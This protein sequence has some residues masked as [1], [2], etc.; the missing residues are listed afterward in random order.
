MLSI[1]ESIGETPRVDRGDSRRYT[2]RNVC[3]VIQVTRAGPVPPVAFDSV[4]PEFLDTGNRQE[5][6][7]RRE[8]RV[9][10]GA[11][12]GVRQ[13]PVR[14]HVPAGPIIL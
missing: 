14:S 4:L 12:D 13:V 11:G 6:G 7:V 8:A 10:S 2:G 9:P 3:L 5:A 1:S